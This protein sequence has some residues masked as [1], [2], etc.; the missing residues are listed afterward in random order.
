MPVLKF[1]AQFAPKVKDGSKPHTVRKNRG[2]ERIVVGSVLKLRC[3]ARC[4]RITHCTNVTPITITVGPHKPF[5]STQDVEVV[6]GADRLNRQQM[7]ELAVRDGFKELADFAAYF[8]S[9][10]VADRDGVACFK[11]DLISWA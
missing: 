7:V 4:L 6:L 3:D 9:K 10:C 1:M 11:G 2:K 5:A 8:R